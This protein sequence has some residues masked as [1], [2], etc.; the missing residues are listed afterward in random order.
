MHK[1]K[2]PKSKFRHQK[3]NRGVG[4]R[5]EHHGEGGT[6]NLVTSGGRERAPNK[7]FPPKNRN[8]AICDGNFHFQTAEM[9]PAWPGLAACEVWALFYHA[10]LSGEQF[11]QKYVAIS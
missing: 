2:V 7:A 5:L 8:C 3:W 1:R 4:V 11:E 6:R 9:A 10:I